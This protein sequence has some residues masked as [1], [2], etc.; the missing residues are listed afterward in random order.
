M[1]L[2]LIEQEKSE[3]MKL[4]FLLNSTVSRNFSF[5]KNEKLKLMSDQMNERQLLAKIRRGDI[6]QQITLHKKSQT[7]R[8][9]NIQTQI[10]K[11][12]C[13]ELDGYIHKARV[14]NWLLAIY[15]YRVVTVMAKK[16]QE[17]RHAKHIW[18]SLVQQ[19]GIISK[20]IIPLRK[21]VVTGKEVNT[22]IYLRL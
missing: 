4:R 11:N 15:S 7:N 13:E 6:R 5:I 9:Q 12:V 8:K 17:L 10:F 20:F 21:K 3:K 14:Q 22:L 19:T 1:E 16:Y 2:E 18:K